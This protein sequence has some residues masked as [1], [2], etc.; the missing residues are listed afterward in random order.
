[1]PEEMATEEDDYFT[2]RWETKLEHQD[3]IW[4]MT[5]KPF[6]RVHG[7]D[8]TQERL[9]VADSTTIKFM[10]KITI[11]DKTK[12]KKKQKAKKEEAQTEEATE[13]IEVTLG[14]P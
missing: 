12:K 10:E 8:R 9:E 14:R 3:S 13:A 11:I 4:G 2:D 1:M 5:L 7:S 6:F